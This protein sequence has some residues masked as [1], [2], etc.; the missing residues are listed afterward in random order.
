MIIAT[1]SHSKKFGDVCYT[2][3]IFI[4][5]IS[6]YLVERLITKLDGGSNY[7]IY[8]FL[9]VVFS[10]LLHFICVYILVGTRILLILTCPDYDFNTSRRSGDASQYVALR[11]KIRSMSIFRRFDSVRSSLSF[12]VNSH[13]LSRSST[14]GTNSYGNSRSTYNSRSNISRKNTIISSNNMNNV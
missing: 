12:T 11:S 10:C 14:S 2:F 4:I 1:G 13:K 6:D 8:F 3:V 5:N 7:D 9:T